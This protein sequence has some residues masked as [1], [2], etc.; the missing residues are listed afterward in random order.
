MP[1]WL[2]VGQCCRY[3]SAV[4]RSTWHTDALSNVNVVL[5][6]SHPP[7]AASR[8]VRAPVLN[9]RELT[10]AVGTAAGYTVV[11]HAP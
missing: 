5:V 9:V 11:P 4:G 6:S 8:R 2:R 1:L 7:C 3:V 10:L